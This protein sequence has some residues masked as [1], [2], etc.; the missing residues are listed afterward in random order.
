MDFTIIITI[1]LFLIIFNVLVYTYYYFNP[2]LLNDGEVIDLR[3]KKADRLT[4]T[5]Y[6][7]D[8]PS[9]RYFYDGWVRIDKTDAQDS[10]YC[11]FN[12]G[13]GFIV[14]LKGHVLSI[15][16]GGTVDGSGIVTGTTIKLL[17]IAPNL[18]FQKWVY[19]CIN[20]DGN[21]VDSYLN[22][23]L[24]KSITNSNIIGIDKTKAISVGTSGVGGR[25]ARFRR[26][27]GN[28]NPQT[29]WS[30]YMLGPGVS[31][32]DDAETGNY[33]AK[34]ALLKNDRVKRSLTLF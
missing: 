10:T 12:Q 34:L 4:L 7:T 25:L 21:T 14:A 24:T 2:E 13:T 3:Q 15:L 1:V 11:I 22:G 9:I 29:V 8:I 18:P 17:D 32:T 26:E 20:V 31:D 28:M 19:F 16:N 5:P 6:D 27:V 30:T 33:K 23:K